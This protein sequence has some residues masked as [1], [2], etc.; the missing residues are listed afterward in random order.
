MVGAKGY[1]QISVSVKATMEICCDMISDDLCNRFQ[2]TSNLS[3]LVV[4]DV[5]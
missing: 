1:N 5:R 2:L 3:I 4:I